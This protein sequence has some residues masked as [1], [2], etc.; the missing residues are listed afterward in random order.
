MWPGNEIVA[1]FDP[2]RIPPRIAIRLGKA[3]AAIIEEIGDL[4]TPHVQEQPAMIEIALPDP[5]YRGID[6][7]HTTLVVKRKSVG[8]YN[9]RLCV[10][11]DTVPID[12]T[13]FVSSPTANRCGV[14]IICLIDSQT[15]WPAHA[16]DISQAFSQA[17]N[18]HTDD[19]AIVLP[20]PTIKLT[21]EK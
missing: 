14:K 20:P 21:W 6:R 18:R 12:Q 9:G 11:V 5:K 2:P 10:R 7:A 13:A 17:G 19:R 4:L 15:Q 1:Q 3:R 8:S 16:L